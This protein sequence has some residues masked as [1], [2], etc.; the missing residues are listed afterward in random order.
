MSENVDLSTLSKEDLAKELDRRNKAEEQALST[1]K[2]ELAAD[3]EYFVIETTEAF[4]ELHEKLKQLKL[5]VI[6]QANKLY[7]RMYEIEGKE[8]KE[9][10][11]FSRISADG[12]LKVTVDRQE[13]LAFTDEAE[14]HIQAIR[15]IF[16][17]KF[18]GRN[19]GFYNLLDT[20]LMK[21][22]KGEY[23]PKLLAKARNQVKQLGDEALIT[24]FNKLEGCQ[25][26]DGTSLYARAYEKDANGKWQ[27]IV[28]QFSSL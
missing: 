1:A 4:K 6:T 2:K 18:E 13:R 9:V 12:S 26:V 10:K 19:K 17:E 11:S 8:P 25:R 3:N 7:A 20:I 28:I 5:A 27:D 23:D 15:D 21:G 14:V 24:E 16:K 22:R